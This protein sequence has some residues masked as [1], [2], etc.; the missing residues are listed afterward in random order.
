[1]N[2][3]QV[4]SGA[5]QGAQDMQNDRVM[6]SVRDL[7]TQ[8]GETVIHE[9]LD[10]T[11]QKEQIVALVGGSGS[12]KTTLLKQML[13]LLHPYHGDVLI[14]GMAPDDPNL[15]RVAAARI[16]M[17]FQQGALF[18]TFPVIENVAFPLMEHG[19]VSH[20]VA[21]SCAATKLQMVGL[22]MSDAWKKPSDLSGGMIK[23][24]ALARA[25]IMD[26]PLLLLDE[27]TAGLD[28]EASEDFVSL[29]A[30][31]HREM[32]L[33]VVMV[34]HD[35]DTIFEVSTHVAVLAEK[36]VLV[37][38]TPENV[39]KFEHPF[40]NEFF[41]GARGKRAQGALKS[42]NDLNELKAKQL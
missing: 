20:E 7:T 23:R 18:S 28:P 5:P 6:I 21:L 4:K 25:L 33:T 8:F 27:P 13:G 35:L 15:R 16:G 11:V 38:D 17:L 37:M 3:D 22:Q 32:A 31:M 12:G 9:H 29:L 26:P 30:A 2:G 14:Q 39:V 19:V 1:M 42:R 40:I 41:N 34:T 36:R 24:V 10:L